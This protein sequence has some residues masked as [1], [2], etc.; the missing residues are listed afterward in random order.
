[1][2]NAIIMIG[3][4]DSGKSNYLARAWEDIR[5]G[6]AALSLVDGE[7]IEY[8]EELLS[9]LFYGKFAPRSDKNIEQS[10]H[11]IK[12]T[13]RTS[14]SDES[15]K[16]VVPDVTGE[17]WKG[18]VANSDLP[19]EWMH[20]LEE[21]TGALMF[22][23]VGSEENQQPL[24]WV[25]SRRL[26]SI[27]GSQG[28]E[29]AIPTQVVY[30]ELLRFL[31]TRLGKRHAGAHRKVAIVIT[32]WDRLDP[33][34]RERPPMDFIRKEFPL[35]AGR[36]ENISDLEI[37]LFG[38]SVVGGDLDA[39]QNFRAH[40]QSGDIKDFGYTVVQEEDGAISQKRDVTLPLSWFMGGYG[41]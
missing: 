36:I 34:Y 22:L 40:F 13:V 20:S 38:I 33:E 17:L 32:A 10:R 29:V 7:N 19:E 16:L 5:S 23:R 14:D 8:L 3:Q 27:L 31:Q 25:A 26:L 28:A 11:D 15:V 2:K 1:M 21:A 6:T 18:A 24:D 37:K 12:L 35:L 39:D 9:H 41:G 30:S 4:P